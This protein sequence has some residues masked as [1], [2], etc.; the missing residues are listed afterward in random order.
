MIDIKNKLILFRKISE[1][2]FKDVTDRIA[3]IVH[4]D[5]SYMITFSDS[6]SFHA[7]LENVKI[8]EHREN[9][10]LNDRVVY[11]ENK[12]KPDIVQIKLFENSDEG[13]LLK[14][15][16]ENGYN[17]CCGIEDV[18]LIK[19][20]EEDN[21]ILTYWEQ[22]ACE[23]LIDTISQMLCSQFSK[24][25]HFNRESVLY[26]YA[27]KKNETYELEGD[28]ICPFK[29]NKSQ[30]K[31]IKNSLTNK[32]SIIKGP[33]GTG[34]TQ[35]ILNLICN[36]ISRG[37]RVAIISANNTAVENIE[38]KLK[39]KGYDGLV[40][41]LGNGDRKTTFFSKDNT[42]KKKEVVGLNKIDKE[43]LKL[44]NKLFEDENKSK[45][46]KDEI[47]KLKLEKE[48]YEK[49]FN[50][51]MLDT[52]K[53][54]FRNSHELIKYVTNYQFD[55]NNKN[56]T[57][58]LWLKLIF[59]YGFKKSL[60]KIEDRSQ[61]VTSLEYRY[62]ALKISELL[63]ELDN[64]NALLDKDDLQQLIEK[65]QHVSKLILDD[66]INQNINLDAKFTQKDYKKNF[67][68][69]I[70]RFPIIT[71]TA[72]SFMSSIDSDFF[73][74]Y[75]IIDESS[76]VSIPY[77]IP[78]LNKC[79]NLVVVGDDKQLSPIESFETKCNV[80]SIFDCNKHSLITSFMELYPKVITTL[81]EHY[82]C[83]PSIIGFCNLKY[84]NNMLIPFTTDDNDI[85]PL[86]LHY[87]ADG[88]H[89]RRIYN[90]ERKGVYNQ[91]EIDTIEEILSNSQTAKVDLSQIGIVSPYRLQIDLMQKK[92]KDIECDTIHKFQG[93]EKDVILFS[94]VIDSKMSSRDLEFVDNPN[95]INV[96]V[97]R[98]IKQFI[99]I[100]DETV[101]NHKGKEIHDLINYIS[102]KSMNETVFKSK[103]ISVFDYLYK[104]KEEERNKIL[105][106]CSSKSPYA[107]EKLLSKLLDDIIIDNKRF[108]QFVVQ[109][110]VK[111]KNFIFDLNKLDEDE[112][113]YIHNNCSVDFLIKDGVNQDVICLI[114]V[115][116]VAYHENNKA[117]QLKDTLKN[118]IILKN[119][120]FLLRLKTNGSN[121]KEQI[122]QVFDAYLN[123]FK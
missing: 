19:Y 12:I 4:E 40:A 117:Q 108:S 85:K 118:N 8:F 31:A 79:K 35:T 100:A 107:S 103:T 39:E 101:F 83:A 51:K 9:I 10:D 16:C 55:T 26:Y 53:F 119:N 74:D 54:K 59:K 114:E 82:R 11:Y 7:K 18:K 120:L 27:N 89:M 96:T 112:Q 2:E 80:E 56:F 93:R 57:F 66:Y 47:Q 104:E 75:V 116:G 94:P 5:K 70:K 36:L 78:L 23:S 42:F 86:Q 111:L 71:S 76:Q 24:I 72:I 84:Y 88:N 44:L 73:V 98:A 63:K 29:F 61:F 113:T 25:S 91:R 34:K 43:H 105:E 69:F 30:H 87:T 14:L 50:D 92:F 49:F 45:I 68:S 20:S 102:Y 52:T 17:F 58:F 48:Y 81:L 122:A 121:E 62:Y 65:Y 110:Q 90:G 106:G 21:N 60:L 1:T 22:C 6:L 15:F 115:D 3:S 99:L 77:T 32:I 38:E 37:K 41:S 46:L 109:E 97:S 95:M 64:L 28:I 33:P 13:K 67:N 123:Q